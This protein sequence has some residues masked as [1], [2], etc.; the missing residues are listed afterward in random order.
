[1]AVTWWKE[2]IKYGFSTEPSCQKVSSL[3]HKLLFND[4]SGPS[5]P[6]GSELPPIRSNII[7]LSFVTKQTKQTCVNYNLATIN[8]ALR[9]SSAS[10]SRLT[11]LGS[12]DNEGGRP[13]NMQQETNT[14]G[15]DCVIVFLDHDAHTVNGME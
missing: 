5:L 8:V 15:N 9:R 11:T 14:Y 6:K 10:N 4:I 7:D 2:L 3:Y 13:C 1:M 12:D